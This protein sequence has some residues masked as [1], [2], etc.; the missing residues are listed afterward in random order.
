M[1]SGGNLVG[2][3]YYVKATNEQILRRV[4]TDDHHRLVLDLWK[5]I[6]LELERGQV[7]WRIY[8]IDLRAEGIDLV[9]KYTVA[10]I[11]GFFRTIEGEVRLPTPEIRIATMPLPMRLF[12]EIKYQIWKTNHP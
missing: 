12:Q 4:G 1:S 8:T 3:D 5:F 6:D 7:S 11:L 2:V 9:T 10:E